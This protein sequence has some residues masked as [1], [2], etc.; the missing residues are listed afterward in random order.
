MG[1][2]NDSADRGIYRFI[3]CHNYC[4]VNHLIDLPCQNRGW[5]NL[6]GHVDCN[7][8]ISAIFNTISTNF[9]VFAENLSV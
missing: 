3:V 4:H 2:R 5:P 7:P 8:L 9:R 6:A 1:R